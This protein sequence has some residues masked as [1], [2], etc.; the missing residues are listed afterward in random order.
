MKKLHFYF[1]LP[2]LT[3][4]S[5]Q[6]NDPFFEDPFGNDMFK[7]VSEMQQQMDKMFERMHQQMEART[8]QLNHPGSQ[9][10]LP[11]TQMN[12]S[13][14]V[15]QGDHYLYDTGI[16]PGKENEIHLSVENNRVTFKAKVTTSSDTN[17]TSHQSVSMM[18][19]SETLPVDVDS[20]T[21]KMEEKE[22]IVITVK[23]KD[24]KIQL[25]LSGTSI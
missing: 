14:F 2:F 9:F 8:K 4:L 25:P 19:R 18:Q 6:A 5:L 20:S 7:E 3:L 21:L 17:N 11:S 23:K 13:M 16:R 1:T 15:D 24:K 10:Y 12:Q 22:T